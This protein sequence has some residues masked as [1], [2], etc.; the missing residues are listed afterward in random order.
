[1]ISPVLRH[2]P[3]WALNVT[4]RLNEEKKALSEGEDFEST[5]SSGY[6]LQQQ[7]AFLFTC[8]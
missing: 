3:G 8:R 7:N 6:I 5:A 2:R 1:M 4:Y